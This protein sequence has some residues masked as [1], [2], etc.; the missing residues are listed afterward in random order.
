MYGNISNNFWRYLGEGSKA[1]Y[2]YSVCV[3]S[4]SSVKVA[5]KKSSV[6][7]FTNFSSIFNFKY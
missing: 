3:S 6:A 7:N 2:L 4:V 5:P 1:G